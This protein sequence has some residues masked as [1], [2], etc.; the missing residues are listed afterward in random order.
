MRQSVVVLLTIILLILPSVICCT[1]RSLVNEISS[2]SVPHYIEIGDI[3]FMDLKRE[4]AFK[5]NRI[6]NDH[7]ALYIGNNQFI[8][9]SPFGGV[10]ISNYEYFLKRYTNHVFG[11]VHNITI[12]ARYFAVQ[13]T[14]K[15]LGHKYQ[16]SKL[17]SDKG[18]D[19][20]WYDAE[21]IW[22]A[23]YNLGIDIDKNSWDDP[24]TVT[25][26]EILDDYDVETYIVH[27][28]PSYVQRGDIIL[29]D[30]IEY[31]TIWNIPGYSN[32]HAAIYLGREYRDGSY[33][34]QTG[35]SGVR[36]VTFDFYHLWS[37]NFT[38]YYVNNANSTQ[39]ENA[40][41]WAFEQLGLKYQFFFP[42]MNIYSMGE[43]GL[44]CEDSSNPNVKTADRFYCMEL[45][46]AAYYNQGIDIDYNGW[47][48]LYPTPPPHVKWIFKKIWEKTEGILW[49]PF[50][51]VEG[52][53]IILSENTTKRISW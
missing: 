22:A 50:A 6:S 34:I 21:L 7:I 29:M 31:D 13:W 3:L 35:S 43:L 37:Q 49:G 8:H 18:Y 11:Y 27:Q 16:Y 17:I 19:E 46:W 42:F 1:T 53:D 12:N 39:I 15:Q 10:R 25:I 48:E 33:F 20:K 52:N 5:H 14:F 4:S 24:K 23:Y 26:Q 41:F 40:I 45:V 36:T 30:T 38:F 2:S 44:K 32:D 28:V 9:A 51:Y 47:Q